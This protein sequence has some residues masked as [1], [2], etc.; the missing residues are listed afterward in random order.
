MYIYNNIKIIFYIVFFSIIF[1]PDFKLNLMINS[2]I[3]IY[4]IFYF[5]NNP[6]EQKYNKKNKI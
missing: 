6:P 4:Q 5:I 3:F 1:F 2:I